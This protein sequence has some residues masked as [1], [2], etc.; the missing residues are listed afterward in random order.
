MR[1]MTC[2]I[3]NS[4]AADG[5]NAWALRR[6]L[7]C[8]TILSRSPQVVCFQEVREGQF[9]DFKDAF[10]G[11][12]A[13]GAPDVPLGR[14]PLNS[15]F[16]RRDAFRLL[17]TNAFWLSETPHVPGSSS[18]GSAN[19]RFAQW[20]HLVESDSQRELAVVNTHL[21]HMSGQARQEGARLINEWAGAFPPELPMIL[22]GDMNCDRT[23]A[24]IKRFK[25]SGWADTH[26]AVHGPEDPGHTVHW[27]LGPDHLVKTRE[28]DWWPTEQGK[29]D[30]IFT[31]GGVAATGAE[32]IRDSENGRYPSDHYFVSA[33]VE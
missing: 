22:T 29:V 13:C 20:V 16:F 1:I 4:T 28:L 31:R 6:D 11:F 33:D 32:I 23:S 14:D 18:W 30:W 26:E 9:S 5:E 15:I 8:R 24:A 7:C 10:P 27:F 21:D 2:N 3:R 17:A 12:D 19:V 25:E